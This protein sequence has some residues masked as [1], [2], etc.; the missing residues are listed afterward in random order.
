MTIKEILN[1]DADDLDKI[2]TRHLRGLVQSLALES[3]KRI[4]NLEKSGLSDISFAYND[5]NGKRITSKKG[6]RAALE[7]EFLR[8][9]SFL[10]DESSKISEIRKIVKKHGKS[11]DEVKRNIEDFKKSLSQITPDF[12][13]RELYGYVIGHLIQNTLYDSEQIR[14]IV[15]KTF[16]SRQ[17]RKSGD[18]LGEIVQNISSDIERELENQSIFGKTIEEILK[19]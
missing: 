17:Y 2:S 19:G 13:E 12:S 14:Q 9:R 7:R 15:T 18:S 6:T 1:L 5:I 3:N 16:Q 10:E 8:A 11:E 4:A